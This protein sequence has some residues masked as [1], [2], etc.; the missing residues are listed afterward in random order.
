MTITLTQ[1]MGLTSIRECHSNTIC[2]FYNSLDKTHSEIELDSYQ[3]DG[4]LNKTLNH[5]LPRLLFLGK[6]KVIQ[7]T[8]LTRKLKMS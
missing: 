4:T 2:F 5:L 7:F 8:R 3:I 6:R 1:I